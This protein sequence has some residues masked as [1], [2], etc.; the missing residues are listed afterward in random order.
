M[1]TYVWIGGVAALFISAFFLL[2][3]FYLRPLRHIQGP[4]VTIGSTTISVERA[5]TP[6]EQERGLSYRTA[7]ASSSGMLFVFS[8]PEYYQFWMPHMNF[9]LDIIWIDGQGTII[10]IAHRVPPLIEGAPPKTYS[11]AHP[12]QYV[13]EVNGGFSEHHGITEGERVDMHL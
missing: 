5:D 9:P 7:L 13:L 12:A 10:T 4:F 8:H 1:K 2:S 11:P 3:G 6:E